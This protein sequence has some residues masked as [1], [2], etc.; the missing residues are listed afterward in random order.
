MSHG[1]PS[2]RQASGINPRM[3][4]YDRTVIESE[5]WP[6][7]LSC[8]SGT[9]E[10]DHHVRECEFGILKK[11]KKI[12]FWLCFWLNEECPKLLSSLGIDHRRTKTIPLWNSSGKKEFF[13]A[14]LYVW[15][16]QYW[17]LCNDLVVF[18][19]W[20]GVR[21]LSF[22]IDTA[23]ECIVW[24]PI[25]SRLWW[26]TVTLSLSHWYPG[27]GVVLVCTY[28]RSLHY[29]LSWKRSREDRSLR[30]PRDGHSSSL[31]SLCFAI[32]CRS[33]ELLS[34]ELSLPD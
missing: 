11:K 6:T 24:W 13:R 26:I 18:K 31:I 32:S 7:Y 28:S 22:S 19:L 2:Q 10:F 29:Y 17:E 30:A 21:Y 34:S 23:P 33:S 1:G 15:F 20:A 14:S 3:K 9:I 27:S 8:E 12:I 16:L 5:A 4:F 25:G